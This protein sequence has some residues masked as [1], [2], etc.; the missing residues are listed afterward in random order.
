VPLPPTPNPKKT[1][2]ILFYSLYVFQKH[3]I[4]AEFTPIKIR[5]NNL[6]YGA[7]MYNLI[8]LDELSHRSKY[9]IKNLGEV[10]F[11]VMTGEKFA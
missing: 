8:G 6:Y 2:S 3:L 7:C 11:L 5:T 4:Q 1:I 10:G 9:R